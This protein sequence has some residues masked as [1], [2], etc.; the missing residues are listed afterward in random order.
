MAAAHYR[1][2]PRYPLIASSGFR[3]LRSYCYTYNRLR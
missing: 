3:Y 1:G 2:Q